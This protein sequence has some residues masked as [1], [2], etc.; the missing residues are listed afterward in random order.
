MRR[1]QII[2]TI[3]T[4]G[5]ALAWVSFSKNMPHRHPKNNCRLFRTHATNTLLTCLT[6]ADVWKTLSENFFGLNLS[7]VHSFLHTPDTETRIFSVKKPSLQEVRNIK[8]QVSFSPKNVWCL[9]LIRCYLLRIAKIKIRGFQ[10]PTW[11]TIVG[12]FPSKNKYTNKPSKK[13][14]KTFILP[15][16][17]W[18]ESSIHTLGMLQ[19]YHPT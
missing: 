10:P 14:G 4:V 17:L 6:I 15:T 13:M 5:P 2:F 18:C 3:K 11:M 16:F 19:L 1:I 7:A 12:D 9:M 8:F